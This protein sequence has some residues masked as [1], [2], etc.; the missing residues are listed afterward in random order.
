[1]VD[2][3]KLA[4]IIIVACIIELIRLISEQTRRRRQKKSTIKIKLNKNGPSNEWYQK[5]D[6]REWEEFRKYG[7]TTNAD[8][9]QPQST[10]GKVSPTGWTFNEKTQLWEPPQK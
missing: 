10:T 3:K 9:K 2:T 4:L 5:Q 1:M 8:F 7:T 6:R